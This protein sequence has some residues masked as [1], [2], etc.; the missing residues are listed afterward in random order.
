MAG[1]ERREVLHGACVRVG[2]ERNLPGLRDL[3]GFKVK[4]SLGVERP[5]RFSKP[6]RS[7]LN[8]FCEKAILKKQSAREKKDSSPRKSLVI[9]V[10]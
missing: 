4:V 2:L 9:P 8:S 6:G 5:S 10:L 1:F 3:E 7:S